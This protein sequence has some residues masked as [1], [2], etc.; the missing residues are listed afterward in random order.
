MKYIYGSLNGNCLPACSKV[1]NMYVHT[2]FVSAMTTIT[3][4]VTILRLNSNEYVELQNSPYVRKLPVELTSYHTT[5]HA[6]WARAYTTLAILERIFI[7]ELPVSVSYNRIWNLFIV[8]DF[9]EAVAS[10]CREITILLTIIHIGIIQISD[11]YV[12][13]FSSTGFTSIYKWYRWTHLP[14]SL[15]VGLIPPSNTNQA[16]YSKFSSRFIPLVSNSTVKTCEYK[17]ASYF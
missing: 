4:W 13:A 2:Q 12:L 9:Y 17:D 15:V 5:Q 7:R 11:I 6:A 8:R 14:A 10:H 16:S 1:T 3:H